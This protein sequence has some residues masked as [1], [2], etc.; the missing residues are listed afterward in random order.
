MAEY[1]FNTSSIKLYYETGIDEKGE[2]I[3]STK[4][5]NRIVNPVSANQI[6]GV[7]DA[8]NTLSSIPASIVKFTKVETVE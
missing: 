1:Y 4:T 6:K 5:L 7:V 3:F 2:P 8:L